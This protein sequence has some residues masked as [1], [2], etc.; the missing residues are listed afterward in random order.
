MQAV[1]F[2]PRMPGARR[3]GWLLCVLLA[4]LLAGCA[5]G[6]QVLEPVRTPVAF[7]RARLVPFNAMAV[8]PADVSAQL[9]SV[10]NDGL[11]EDGPFQPGPGLVIEYAFITLEPG[12]PCAGWFWGFL[13]ND[14]DSLVRLQVRYLDVWNN[15]LAKVQVEGRSQGFFGGSVDEAIEQAGRKIVAFAIEKFY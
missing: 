14:G 7:E 3:A 13:G 12:N 10:I 2:N 1:T 5:A 9:Q 8:V 11:F 6:P 15:E 4:L